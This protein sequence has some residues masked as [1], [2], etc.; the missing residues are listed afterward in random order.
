VSE[1]AR[2]IPIEILGQQYPIRTT[3]DPRY[4]A[5]LAAY[6]EEKIRTTADITP[7]TD[8]VRLAVLAALNIADEYFHLRDGD[9]T[10]QEEIRDRVA[11]IE[12][13]VDEALKGGEQG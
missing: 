6:V 11:R 13:M 2:V 12:L 8:T 1:P 4:V 3:L 10:Q 9:A 5:R 7:T